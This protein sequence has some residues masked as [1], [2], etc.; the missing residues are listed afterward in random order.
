VL[1]TPPSEDTEASPLVQRFSVA[2]PQVAPLHEVLPAEPLLLMGA[3][4][5]PLHPDVARANSIVINHLGPSMNRV[6][7]GIQTSS[8]YVF[9]SDDAY[10]L[11]VSGPAS[12]AFEMV[13]T[14]LLWEGRSA[15]VLVQGTFSGRW[16]DMAR[17]V[18]ADVTELHGDG[19]H[20]PTLGQVEEA[21]DAG[22]YDVLLATHGET[23]SGTLLTE[24]PAISRAAHD[25]GVLTAVD[26]VTTIGAIDF[27][28]S[29]WKIDAA[30]AGGQKALGSIPGFS[31]AAFSPLAWADLQGREGTSPH[32]ALD[33]RLAWAFWGEGKY[34]YTAPVPG[35]LAT[36]EALKQIVDEGLERRIERHLEASTSMQLQLEKLGLELFAPEHCRLPSVIAIKVPEGIDSEQLRSV[37][38]EQY[39]VEISGAFGHNIVRIGQ[40]AEQIRYVR[41]NRTLAALEG[42]LWQLGFPQGV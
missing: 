9:Q 33:A 27:H 16:A 10:V 19:I 15:L 25:R 2:P 4:P 30:I 21:L 5:V 22:D 18:G 24:L 13:I 38:R 32:W 40:M 26:A 28:M 20:P 12:A 29:D 6:I 8:R 34:H 37:M 31:I 17:R 36:Y 11:G 35:T 1:E 7:A 39:G 41:V 23:S 3:G 14:G 42:A